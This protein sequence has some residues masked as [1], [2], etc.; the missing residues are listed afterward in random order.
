ME[1]QNRFAEISDWASQ[2]ATQNKILHDQVLEK[3]NRLMEVSDWANEIKRRNDVLLARVA[4]LEAAI[5]GS[6]GQEKLE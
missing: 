3:Q 4:E 5:S 2:L 1:K 6:T